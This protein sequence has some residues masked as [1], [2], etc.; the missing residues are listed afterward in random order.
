MCTKKKYGLIALIIVILLIVCNYCFNHLLIKGDL[1][2]ESPFYKVFY[3]E[4]RKLYSYQIFSTNGDKID[5]VRNISGNLYVE[6]ISDSLLHA[7]IGSGSNSSQEWFYDIKNNRKSEEFF[8]ISAIHD[9]TIVYMEFTDDYEIR[10]IIRD[11]FDTEVLYKEIIRDFSKTA[12]AST[13]LKNVT[14]INDKTIE[15]EYAIGSN[16][17]IVKEIIMLE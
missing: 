10:L 17:E 7:I 13:D 8:N 16:Y 14:F 1:C 9:S 11:I 4:D 3:D 5:E 6:L 2:E 12:V 15:V